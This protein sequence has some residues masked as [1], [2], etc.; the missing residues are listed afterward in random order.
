MFDLLHTLTT[1]ENFPPSRFRVNCIPYH[2]SRA[3][4]PCSRAKVHQLDVARASDQHV[5][6]LYITMNETQ[7]VQV[8]QTSCNLRQIEPA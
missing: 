2:S 5:L 7:L 1:Q 8:M 4:E 3:V 6:G